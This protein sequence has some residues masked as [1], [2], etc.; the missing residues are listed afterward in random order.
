VKSGSFGL[1]GH[2]TMAVNNLNRILWHEQRRDGMIS[3][4]RPGEFQATITATLQDRN[5]SELFVTR[6]PA[7]TED[8]VQAL[9][10]LI[11]ERNWKSITLT[12]ARNP[13]VE[14][15]LYDRLLRSCFRQAKRFEFLGGI[16]LSLSRSVARSLVSRLC[17]IRVLS[18]REAKLSTEIASILGQAISTSGSLEEFGLSQS[19]ISN[20]GLPALLVNTPSQLRALYLSDCRLIPEEVQQIVHALEHHPN[21]KTLYLNG[22]Q[23]FGTE[24]DS[25]LVLGLEK[26]FELEN[27][28][29]PANNQHSPR[30]QTYIE[31]NRA[32]RRLLRTPN[33]L[34][35]LWPLVL[36]RL[37]Q[38]RSMNEMSKV[39]AMYFFVHQLHGKEV[40]KEATAA[41]VS[42]LQVEDYYEEKVDQQRHQ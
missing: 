11:G 27:V 37:S 2:P 4:D 17:A 25:T 29:L 30:I 19:R 24:V 26:H 35:A 39:N 8:V 10:Q 34:P 13:E 42:D 18:L 21:L 36:E 22:D 7:F 5:I 14:E 16:D 9:N 6:L 40:L 33:A 12:E 23:Q 28:Q 20:G 38:I 1:T 3:G 41:I 31:L 32:G 15:R